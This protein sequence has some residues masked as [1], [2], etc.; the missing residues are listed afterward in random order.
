[1]FNTVFVP[2]Y[3]NSING[4]WQEI[5][6][7]ETKNSYWVEQDDWQNPNCSDWVEALNLLIQ[8]LEGPIVLVTH[9]L[10]G[11]TVVEWN[12]KYK[13]NI[14]GA[15]IVAVPDVESDYLPKKIVGYQNLPLEKLPFQSVVLASSDDPYSSLDRSKYF[16]NSWGSE[17]I[18]IGDLGHVN[19]ASGIGN[20]PNG[21]TLLNHFVDSLE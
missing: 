9:S 12:K 18:N 19:K 5:W 14:L 16:A 20:W 11:S 21:K 2:G 13:A 1:M 8:S 4:H 6:Y 7:K 10:G 3:G 15:F 17:F